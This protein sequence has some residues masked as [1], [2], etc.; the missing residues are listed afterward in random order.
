MTATCGVTAPPRMT[1]SGEVSD[2]GPFL[3]RQKC[4]TSSQQNQITSYRRFYK[5]HVQC[6]FCGQLTR[7]R[8][9]P[10][11]RVVRCGSCGRVLHGEAPQIGLQNPTDDCA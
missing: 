4:M 2:F 11:E 1:I 10:S 8:L 9:F 7:G 3:I 5:S 6:D